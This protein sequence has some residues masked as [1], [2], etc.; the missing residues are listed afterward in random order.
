MTLKQILPA[1]ILMAILCCAATTVATPIQWED[2]GNYYEYIAFRGTWDDANADAGTHTYDGA[3]GH[4]ATLTTALENDFVWSIFPKTRAWLGGYQIG[5]PNPANEPDGN[6]AWVTEETWEFTNW[7]GGE[8]NDWLWREDHLQF[9]EDKGAWNDML[10]GRKE[11][12]YIIEYEKSS[13][14]PE[15]STMVLLGFG[16]LGFAGFARKGVRG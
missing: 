4:L 15:P 16:I 14:V 7:A 6:W 3:T 2:N 11:S 8:P 13:P 9:W 12:G 10:N 1:A 5:T